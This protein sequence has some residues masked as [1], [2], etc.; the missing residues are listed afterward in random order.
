MQ[1]KQL[2]HVSTIAVTCRIDMS[3]IV[4]Q[5]MSL[6]RIIASAIERVIFTVAW[7]NRADGGNS[8]RVHKWLKIKPLN[9]H[10]LNVDLIR[11]ITV[12]INVEHHH[13]HHTS[14]ITDITPQTG[15]QGLP[16][17]TATLT[18]LIH[19]QLANSI[20]ELSNH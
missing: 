7:L 13:Y 4:H 9:L 6:M 18:N 2:V 3:A 5:V 17:A 16:Y 19:K 12:T 1:I 10:I 8:E 15:N 11:A 20:G 14:L